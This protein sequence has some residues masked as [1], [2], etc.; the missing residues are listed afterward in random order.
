MTTVAAA[1]ITRDSKLLICQRRHDD[2]HPLQWEFPGGKV[3][4]GE[5]P[6]QALE[7]E[8]R[9]ELGIDA[10]IGKELFRARHR[11]RD[12]ETELVLIFFRAEVDSASDLQNLVFERF[13]WTDLQSLL[14]YRFLAADNELIALLASGSIRLE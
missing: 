7:R 14:R 8:L 1:L 5:T 10:I 11:Y 2:T 13:E 6:M 9:E 12:S 3:E 4:P